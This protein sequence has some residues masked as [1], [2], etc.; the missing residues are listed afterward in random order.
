MQVI[1][2]RQKQGPIP[3]KRLPE[4]YLLCCGHWL[5]HGRWLWRPTLLFRDGGGGQY[6]ILGLHNAHVVRQ[7]LLGAYLPAWVPRKHDLHFDA[8]HTWSAVRSMVRTHLWFHWPPLHN[9]TGHRKR[10]ASDSSTPGSGPFA[11]KCL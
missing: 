5:G 7:G 6:L 10:T 11:D 4:T 3:P 8:Q 2:G 1:T 9:R